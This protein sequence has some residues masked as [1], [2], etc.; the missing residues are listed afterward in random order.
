MISD[1]RN[2]VSASLA[3]AGTNASVRSVTTQLWAFPMML[4]PWLNLLLVRF[5]SGVRAS[6]TRWGRIESDASCRPS[7][8]TV[9]D[10]GHLLHEFPLFFRHPGRFFLP[11]RA[12]NGAAW[13]TCVVPRLRFVGRWSF[14]WLRPSFTGVLITVVMDWFHRSRSVEATASLPDAVVLR[15]WFQRNGTPRYVERDV[16]ALCGLPWVS[17]NGE[18]RFAFL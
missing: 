16:R 10:S 3:M 14:L 12:A 11:A 9:S 18:T 13:S 6:A 4:I 5:F 2:A 15:R 8:D 1:W 7:S 17:E